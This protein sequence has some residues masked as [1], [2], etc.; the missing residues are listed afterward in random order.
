MFRDEHGVH[1]DSLFVFKW[2]PKLTALG[3][4]LMGQKCCCPEVDGRSHPEQGDRAMGQVPVSP[5]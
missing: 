3:S 5:F 1:V 2:V 4:L